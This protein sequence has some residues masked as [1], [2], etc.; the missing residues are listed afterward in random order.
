MNASRAA[1]TPTDPLALYRLRDGIYAPDLLIVAVVELDLFSWLHHR[2]PPTRAPHICDELGLDPRAC[3]VLIT[4]LVALGLLERGPEEE[5]LLSKM[6]IEHLVAGSRWDLRPYYAS[7]RARPACIELLDVLR[8]G[9]PASWASAPGRQDWSNRLMEPEFAHEITAA[10]D[11]RG[12]YLGPAFAAALDRIK[13]V[14]RALDIGGGSGVYACALLDRRPDLHVSVFER[15]P[16]DQAARQVLAERGYAGR[17]DVVTGDMFSDP[18]PAGYDLHIFSHVLHDWSE[19]Q[20]RD[21]IASSFAALPPGGWLV[22][23]DMHVDALKSG[24]LPVAEYSVLLMHSTLGKCWSVS[25][26]EAILTDAGFV[27]VRYEDTTGDRSVVIARKPGGGI[28]R[29]PFRQA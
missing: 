15:P 3:D 8:T 11:A 12:R 20:V 27:V 22:D 2:T 23:H 19:G 28:C 26:L 10:M 21:L 18:L 16:V 13:G 29:H 24:P 6:A 4:Y 1:K 7:L 9:T 25:E 14:R 5:I 17:V